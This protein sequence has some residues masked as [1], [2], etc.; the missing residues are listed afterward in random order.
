MQVW[1]LRRQNS[2]CADC[3]FGQLMFDW[4]NSPKMISKTFQ[5]AYEGKKWRLTIWKLSKILR[6]ILGLMGMEPGQSWR[7]IQLHLFQACG[8]NSSFEWHGGTSFFFSVSCVCFVVSG[9]GCVLYLVAI[10][11]NLGHCWFSVWEAALLRIVI[12]KRMAWNE[13][14][15]RNHD[16]EWGNRMEAT[17]MNQYACSSASSMNIWLSTSR[18]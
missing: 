18:R 15:Q 9:S 16:F 13:R 1:W 5:R 3:L 12:D 17:K 10:Q 2:R 6:W 14:G 11:P 7:V 8:L 4:A